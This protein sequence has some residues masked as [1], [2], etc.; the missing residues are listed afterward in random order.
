M[1][2]VGGGNRYVLEIRAEVLKFVAAHVSV[3]RG[4]LDRMEIGSQASSDAVAGLETLHVRGC[5]HER[6]HSHQVQAERFQTQVDGK[7]STHTHSDTIL[8]GGAMA[9]TH[10]GAVLVTA[11]MSDDLVAGGGVRATALVDLWLSGLIGMEEKI[12]T[13]IADGALVEAFGTHFEREYGL[14]N[15]V[16]GFA[17]FSGSVYTTAATGFRPLFKVASGVR[18]LNAGGGAGPAADAPLAAPPSAETAVPPL[19]SGAPPANGMLGGNSEIARVTDNVGDLASA[20]ADAEQIDIAGLNRSVSQLQVGETPARSADAAAEL[21]EA[22]Y[23]AAG[24]IDNV[25]ANLRQRAQL[26]DEAS[27]RKVYSFIYDAKEGEIGDAA[28]K[29]AAALAHRNINEALEPFRDLV[30]V[31]GILEI[32]SSDFQ[33]LRNLLVIDAENARA[34]G[35]IERTAKLQGAIVGLDAV[36]YQH[37]VDLLSGFPDLAAGDELLNN[38]SFAS[39]PPR[40]DARYVRRPLAEGFDLVDAVEQLEDLRSQWLDDV[41]PSLARPE[42]IEDE[43]DKVIWVRNQG[44]QAR[45]DQIGLALDELARSNDPIPAL[46]AQIE[47]AR[48]REAAGRP[49]FT[50]ELATLENGTDII[51]KIVN[52]PALSRVIREQAS[53]SQA[54]RGQSTLDSVATFNTRLIEARQTADWN[55]LRQLSQANDDLITV[56]NVNRRLLE[57]VLGPS[58]V[59]T[60]DFADGTQIRNALTRALDT[61][62]NP[63]D[64]SRIIAAI[65][66]Y[67]DRVQRLIGGALATVEGAVGYEVPLSSSVSQAALVDEFRQMRQQVL[68]TLVQFDIATK[69]D[70]DIYAEMV[71]RAQDYLYSYG[72]AIERVEQGINP[73]SYL[74]AEI[75]YLRYV[76]G[77]TDP[78]READI[79]ANASK[80][81]RLEDVRDRIART[82][83]NAL[84]A[85]NRQSLDASAQPAISANAIRADPSWQRYIADPNAV[86]TLHFQGPTPRRID[87]LPDY[88][89]D[90][91]VRVGA[92]IIESIGRVLDHGAP[93]VDHAKQIKGLANREQSGGD[94]RAMDGGA[95]EAENAFT[96]DNG[97]VLPPA[98]LPS[99]IDAAALEI[100][101]DDA[102][103]ALLNPDAGAPQADPVVRIKRGAL[104]EALDA[105]AAGRD[106]IPVLDALIVAAQAQVSQDALRHQ[107]EVAIL[108]DVRSAVVRIVA[109]HRGADM[110]VDEYEDMTTVRR[111]D[112]LI[113]HASAIWAVAL[114]DTSSAERGV[115][116]DFVHEASNLRRNVREAL[117]TE[118]HF[119]QEMHCYAGLLDA[120]TVDHDADARDNT[121]SVLTRPSR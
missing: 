35:D 48:L 17:S 1:A 71:R 75:D 84:N 76:I 65:D 41:V 8:L 58:E 18:N 112:D 49:R 91:A 26:P 28:F 101:I 60:L 54:S 57:R 24:E 62:S 118:T 44:L 98:R 110:L 61:T 114:A 117:S 120:G 43:V 74:D 4:Q 79:L 14:G 63:E 105:V 95:A 6:A 37:A 66:Y 47:Q 68:D 72:Y 82:I 27:I 64:F 34:A 93:R 20:T 87:L 42:D 73:T 100:A 53:L 103:D 86:D 78:S 119:C 67:D 9:E 2:D 107:D 30:A 108:M 51:D 113:G 80:L 88:S 15:H 21:T 121:C 55:A 81:E 116:L 7:L 40:P 3:R 29:S 92:D 38:L 104:A 16:A 31:Q 33:S 39:P 77:V 22:R 83:A 12:G 94:D 52:D 46:E 70:G 25:V 99:D 89:Q 109:E 69:E 85:P 59:A 102:R 97:Y 13:A 5:L 23:V 19:A 115:P 45:A 106:P 111:I 10:A 56:N 32:G 50:G 96:A 90:D 11:G 36:A